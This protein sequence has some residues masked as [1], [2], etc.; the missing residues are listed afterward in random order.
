[1]EHDVNKLDLVIA[2]AGISGCFGAVATLN[3]DDMKK[4][5]DVNAIGPVYLFQAVVS[6]LRNAEKPKFVVITSVASSIGSMEDIPFTLTNY[7]TSK[8]AINYI[9][10]R[11]HFENEWL[12]AFPISPGYGNRGFLAAEPSFC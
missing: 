1:L 2:N 8:V 7:G 3:V 6:L 10:R 12:I 9:T 5:L 4:M 11:I